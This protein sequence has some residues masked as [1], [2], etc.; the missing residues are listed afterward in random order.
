MIV[1]L[2]WCLTIACAIPAALGLFEVAVCW[3]QRRTAYRGLPAWDSP[4]ER[5]RRALSA[6]RASGSYRGLRQ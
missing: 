4:D 5:V 1:D 3:W 2:L 6:Y